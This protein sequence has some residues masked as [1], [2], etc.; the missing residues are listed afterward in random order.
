MISAVKQAKDNLD[1]VCALPNVARIDTIDDLAAGNDL[2][3]PA[4][5]AFDRAVRDARRAKATRTFCAGRK[6]EYGTVRCVI[7]RKVGLWHVH[8]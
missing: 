4:Q 2:F 7:A 8:H 5:L 1:I 3:W 6:P